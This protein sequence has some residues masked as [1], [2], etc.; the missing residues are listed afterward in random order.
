[1]YGRGVEQDVVQ[2]CA[3][4][5]EAH[6]MAHAPRHDQPGIDI[7]QGLIDQHCK[8][9]SSE[10]LIEL[11]NLTG[12]GFIGLK[13]QVLPLHPGSWI[14][15]S[16]LGV[17]IERPSGRIEDWFAG[18]PTCGRH[19]KMLRTVLLPGANTT[20]DDAYLME[21]LSWEGIRSKG[22]L[23]RDLGWRLFTVGQSRLEVRVQEIVMSE[24]GSLW[25]PPAL[26]DQFRDG[27][28]L[29][30]SPDGEIHWRFPGEPSVKGI[31]SYWKQ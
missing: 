24:P 12:C 8:G 7:A 19:V 20:K 10:Q 16:R 2:G 11:K 25:P 18:D 27:A 26:P 31:I 15:F 21:M 23:R 6:A 1:M 17:A 14:E 9:F 29:S 28:I 3:L 13:R 5:Y 30:R 22:E 4:L